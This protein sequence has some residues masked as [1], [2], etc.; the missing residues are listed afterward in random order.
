MSIIDRQNRLLVAEDWKRIYQTFRDANFQ[1]YDFE[2]LRR[3]M[4]DYIRQNY[5]EDFN[6]YIE[7]SEYLAL[8]DLISFL[9]QSI[10]FRVDLNARE[11]FL[12]L[13]ERRDSVLRLARMLSYSPKRNLAAQGLLKF[14]SVQTTQNI[15][16]SNGRNLSGQVILWNDAS[17]PNW[18]DQFIKVI[19]AAMSSTQ[20]FGNPSDKAVIY[21]I[22]TEQYRFEASNTDV[23]VYSFTQTIAGTVMNFEITSTSFSGKTY[24]Y[25]EAPLVGNKLACIYRD[26]GRGPNSGGSGFFLN[27]VQGLLTTGTFA[28]TQPI[29]NGVVEID[30]QNINNTDVWLYRLDEAGNEIE[31]WTMVP[32]LEGNN[33]IYNS[34]A[35]DIRNVYGVVTRA[36]DSI[37][38][39]FSD[40]TFGNIP[41]GTF[42]VY[43]RVSNGLSYTINTQDIRSVTINVPYISQ[44]GQTEALTI[45][46]RL[47]S[48]IINA[49]ETESND[50][51][52][53]NAP[54]AYYTQ[55]RMI[56]AEDYNICPLTV[57]QQVS[58][59]KAV[60]RTSSG[61]SR[62]FDLIDPTGKYSSTTLFGT[63]GI[64]YVDEYNT[65]INFSYQ[66]DTDIEAVI[67]NDI[68]EILR[69]QEVKY[70]Y[71]SRYGDDSIT[72]ENTQWRQ[73]NGDVVSSSGYIATVAEPL[74]PLKLG[75]ANPATSLK[76]VMLG[77]Q[78][79]FDAPVGYY[80]D[81]RNNNVLTLITNGRIPTGGVDYLWAEI[82]SVVGDGTAEGVGRLSTG[83]GPVLL[84]KQIPSGCNITKLIP[85]WKPVIDTATISSMIDLIGANKPFGLRY[86]KESQSWKIIYET[87][88]RVYSNFSLAKAG[89]VSNMQRDASWFVLFTT[90]NEYYTVRSRELRYV[91]E[92]DKEVN[93]YFDAANR[94][95]D[96]KTNT[97]ISDSIEILDINS[98]ADYPEPLTVPVIWNILSEVN[99][100]DGYVDSKKVTIGLGDIDFNGSVDNPEA[101]THLISTT[102]SQYILEERYTISAGQED[103]R[104]VPNTGQV[105]ILDTAP[106]SLGSYKD[107]QYF[108]FIDV[109]LVV[110]LNVKLA[111][112]F[113]PS[114]DY[115]VYR[116][117]SGLKFK[118]SHSA[119]SQS[120]IDPGSSNIIDVYVLTKN[121]DTQFRQWIA[122]SITTKPYPPS[123]DELYD[124]MT[125]SLSMIKSVS[126]EIIYHSV[127]YRVLFGSSAPDELQ[128]VFKVTKT[129]GQVISDN[130]VKSKIIAAVNRFFA[131]ENWDFGDDFY[132]SELS[133]YVMKELAPNISNFVIVP[134]FSTLAFGSLFEIRASS[135]Q[136]F[137]SGA[138][139]NDVEIISGITM[140]NIKSLSIT[141]AESAVISQNIISSPYGAE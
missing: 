69:K 95:Y 116:G 33:I 30:S 42:R 80:F 111:N 58:K 117:R 75:D 141:A 123:S 107:G 13:A 55:N 139:V 12:E 85:R 64:I 8:I 90:N 101:F 65:D 51:I 22:P 93:F 122:G 109:K 54:S 100:L 26:D 2:N 120:R 114:L 28:I 83:E 35:K 115:K 27:V 125:P 126:D 44:V 4:I 15:L 103:Y 37:N 91:F 31:K 96:S 71:Y 7:S 87:N 129:V 134:K 11:N 74:I 98:Q 94:I 97:V 138:T 110:K 73:I 6:D 5:P 63:D 17:N 121:Y 131:L 14:A 130:D 92:S 81:V 86:S 47:A 39:V 46:L 1:S 77:T 9:G 41:L 20:Q 19:N 53:I 113:V 66:T 104:Y 50:S 21:N 67:Y 36:G 135:D 38:L 108:Y 56:T 24:V 133:A 29:S 76:Y 32:S 52:K 84:N 72:K 68:F 127:S 25:E 105:I 40:G 119:D 136:L 118:Y 128:A 99:G 88:L 61:I 16:D 60:N 34:I 124:L 57:S 89:D 3:T 79:K 62:Y 49:A 132:F 43:Y 45:S 18:H 70:L 112:P 78:L 82:V 106:I 140:T 102:A 59:V 23:P 137:I 48:S 10:A